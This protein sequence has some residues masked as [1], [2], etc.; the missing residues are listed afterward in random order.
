MELSEEAK[1]AR[2]AYYRDY[3]QRNKAKREQA[4]QRHWEKKAAL[5]RAESDENGDSSPDA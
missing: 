5:E 2:R 1:E 4:V 3:Y